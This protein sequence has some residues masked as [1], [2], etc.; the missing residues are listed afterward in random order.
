MLMY[1]KIKFVI[2][3]NND[4]LLKTISKHGKNKKEEKK[5]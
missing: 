5:I 4:E 1:L 2:N 3:I